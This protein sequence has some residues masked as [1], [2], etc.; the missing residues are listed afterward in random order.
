[1]LKGLAV[2]FVPIEA[3]SSMG[4]ELKMQGGGCNMG[5][6]FLMRLM[7]EAGGLNFEGQTSEHTAK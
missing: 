1:M 2:P 4:E 6:M 5:E 3:Q 7:V